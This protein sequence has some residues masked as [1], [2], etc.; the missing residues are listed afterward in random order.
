MYIF[1]LSTPTKFPTTDRVSIGIFPKCFSTAFH[2]I[3]KKLPPDTKSQVA[4]QAKCPP[5][6]T[7]SDLFP[8]Q[9]FPPL[10]FFIPYSSFSSCLWLLPS[11]I[12]PGK[13]LPLICFAIRTVLRFLNW[14]EITS[15]RGWMAVFL[16]LI[17]KHWWYVCWM[18][19]IN[20][21]Q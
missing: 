15:K 19:F 13:M 18:V 1:R 9:K 4:S 7:D 8:L 21:I 16:D 3:Q 12:N 14:K 11:K 17:G 10:R 6:A 2:N 5:K 20:A